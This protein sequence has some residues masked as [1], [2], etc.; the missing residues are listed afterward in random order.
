MLDEVYD[1]ESKKSIEDNLAKIKKDKS[2]SSRSKVI[3]RQDFLD[4]NY[5]YLVLDKDN[6]NPGLEYKDLSS[7]TNEKVAKV[8]DKNTTWKD[9]F[10]K[11]YFK[12]NAKITR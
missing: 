2:Y 3:S 6:P 4:L 7:V 11:N 1:K 10:G 8:F 5:K 9:K 12:P